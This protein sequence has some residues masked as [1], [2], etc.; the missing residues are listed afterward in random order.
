MRRASLLVSILLFALPA[1]AQD[2][3]QGETCYPAAVAGV[4]E[5][6]SHSGPVRKGTLLCI[7]D[8]RVMLASEGRV[9]ALPL[10]DV[11]TIVKPADGIGDGFLKGAAIAALFG[12]LCHECGR[13]A[14][15]WASAIV[16]YGGIGAT[17][18]ALHGGRE[19]LYQRSDKSRNAAPVS[20]AW[21]VRF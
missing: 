11:K 19:I 2:S 16:V 18:D 8:T 6:A 3:A 10:S 5:V 9:E 13:N 4:V 14:G 12:I 15:E 20:V 21:R 1:R 7:G 17:I